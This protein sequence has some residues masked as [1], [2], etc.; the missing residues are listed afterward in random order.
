VPTIIP[1]EVPRVRPP[2]RVPLVRDHEYGV[3]PPVAV[4]V[5]LYAVPTCPGASEV[6]EICKGADAPVR[7]MLAE[8]CLELLETVAVRV[9]VAGVGTVEGVV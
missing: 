8:A 7:V 9:T 4:R 6:V 5:A 1:L 3:V 2:G